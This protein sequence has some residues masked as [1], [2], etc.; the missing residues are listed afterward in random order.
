MLNLSSELFKMFS[1]YLSDE[2]NISDFR[3]YM[4]GLRVDR[5]KLLVDADRVFLNEFEGRYAEFS[6]FGNEEMLKSAL[7][8]YLRSDEAAAA[9]AAGYFV[10]SA[11]ANSSG[12]Q[13]LQTSVGVPVFPAT[14]S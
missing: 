14:V 6:D 7:I 12:S 9:P 4:V 13:S 3:D 8:S 11:S 10:A 2:V 5:Y 1:K